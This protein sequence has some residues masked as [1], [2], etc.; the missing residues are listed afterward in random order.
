MPSAKL[1]TFA[2]F[3]LRNISTAACNSL[4]CTRKPVGRL[5]PEFTNA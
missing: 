3:D 1:Q 2:F 4:H 5:L